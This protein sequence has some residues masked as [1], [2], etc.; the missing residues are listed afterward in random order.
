MLP[1]HER[2]LGCAESALDKLNAADEQID[3]IDER[4]LKEGD[5][6]ALEQLICEREKAMLERREL[7][8]AWLAWRR[9]LQI[10]NIPIP[11]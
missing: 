10:L 8:G 7:Q 3:I 5:F 11:E 9:V 1:E 6:S 4:L 2:I